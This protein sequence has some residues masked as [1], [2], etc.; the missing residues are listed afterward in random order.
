MVF[1]Y[2]ALN[3]AG[4]FESGLLEAENETSVKALVKDKG[5]YLVSFKEVSGK[6]DKQRELFS[7]GIRQRLPVQLARQLSSLLKG[8]VPLFQ[9]LTII[10]NQLG[11]GKARDIVDYLKDQVRGGSS[12]SEAL[13]AYPQIF[14]ELFIY[15]VQAGERSGALDSILSY[16][17]DLLENRAVVRGKIST[18]L[19][20]PVI[21]AVVG[22]GVLLFLMTYVVPMVIKIF[23]RTNQALPLPTQLLMGTAKL[24]NSYLFIFLIAVMVFTVLG[25]RWVR[26]SSRARHALDRL[27]L[28]L[29]L[30]GS[31]YQM[32]TVGRFARIMATLLKSGV[33]MVQSLI[34][35]SRTMKN[36]VIS[37]SI[38][39][40]AEMVEG[41]ADLS[42]ALR[43]TGMFPSYL[44]DM[45]VVGE[46]GGNLE[47]MLSRVSEY[48]EVNVNQRITGLTSMIEPFIIL[49]IGLVVAFVLISILL[50]LFELNKILI[51]R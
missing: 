30:Y 31:L 37:E 26:R 48:Y 44:T 17:A 32:I 23:E 24:V 4:S 9:A 51:K 50:P 43:T 10:A 36:R 25:V 27:L 49:A 8:G 35:V 14:D 42:S 41:G 47:E 39:R 22:A 21:M 15:S 7:F 40:I 20:Y 12:L 46:T 13:K 45:V 1:R 5:L 38:L 34:V 33:T 19:I 16:Q 3:R 28:R 2:R 11:N 18:A 29:P 6:K